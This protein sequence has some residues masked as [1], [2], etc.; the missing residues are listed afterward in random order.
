MYV[1]TCIFIYTYMYLCTHLSLEV[2]FND[3]H[4]I[5]R[6][7]IQHMNKFI[8]ICMYAN[9]AHKH[10]YTHTRRYIY[11]TCMSLI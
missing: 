10:A 5:V 11:K 7:H 3:G 8:C 9:H 1:N 4:I 2:V 6:A